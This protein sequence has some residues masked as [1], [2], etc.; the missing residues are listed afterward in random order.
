MEDNLQLDKE[1]PSYKQ[2][3]LLI[4]IPTNF[5]LISEFS[6]EEIISKTFI[7]F[8][9]TMVN[10]E[11]A[12]LIYAYELLNRYVF[13]FCIDAYCFHNQPL[14]LIS[15]YKSRLA[16]GPLIFREIIK[17][18]TIKVLE[19]KDRYLFDATIL[20]D[21]IKNTESVGKQ[22][23]IYEDVFTYFT[24][25]E[26][27]EDLKLS[28]ESIFRILGTFKSK[29]QAMYDLVKNNYSPELLEA[30]NTYHPKDTLGKKQKDSSILS[31]FKLDKQF[32]TKLFEK[33]D[34]NYLK[35]VY[36]TDYNRLFN[37][38]SL[39]NFKKIEWSGSISSLSYF[40][41]KI[42][43]KPKLK[44]SE[45]LL[46]ASKCFTIEKKEITVTQLTNNNK[47]NASDRGLINSFF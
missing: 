2:F 42:E 3:L 10:N 26:A 41:K 23:L 17:R 22:S 25:K 11:D 9:P 34:S 44:V 36:Q 19:D 14:K 28:M 35:G 7:E 6:R 47:P 15:W 4:E 5:K 39:E 31:T 16:Q 32:T 45:K 46:I 37:G 40:I 29:R 27:F 38:S 20:I 24:G 12:K 21:G 1:S 8:Y 43:S 13:G 30:F 18:Y 33:L